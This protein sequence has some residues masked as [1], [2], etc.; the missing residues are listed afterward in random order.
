MKWCKWIGHRWVTVLL[1][2]NLLA[3]YCSRC[4]IGYNGISRYV[5]TH[6]T[7]INTYAWEK[8]YTE[9]KLGVE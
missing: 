5:D 9:H 3:K 7:E 2:N 4:N 8:Y 1:G 6:K